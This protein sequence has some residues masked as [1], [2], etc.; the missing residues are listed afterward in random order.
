MTKK[1]DKEFLC[2]SCK[3]FTD[4]CEHIS[5]II[6]CLHKKVEKIQYRNIDT[7]V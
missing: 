4:K 3:Y 5:N 6:I 2:D 1:V 7:R